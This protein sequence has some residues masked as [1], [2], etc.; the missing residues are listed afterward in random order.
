M[1][2]RKAAMWGLH[3]GH[4]PTCRMPPHLRKSSRPKA[5]GHWR[6]LVVNARHSSPLI[7]ACRIKLIC[8]N[9]SVTGSTCKQCGAPCKVL[10]GF[11]HLARQPSLPLTAAYGV[12][13]SP[14]F[15]FGSSPR[16][17]NPTHRAGATPSTEVLGRPGAANV[18]QLLKQLGQALHIICNNFRLCH[19][20]PRVE[21]LL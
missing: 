19:P 12:K 1:A 13:V 17:N 20:S 18:Y 2:R 7:H 4:K 10:W 15:T 9:R 14:A 16:G 5:T 8:T 21:K 11:I 6:S 3:A